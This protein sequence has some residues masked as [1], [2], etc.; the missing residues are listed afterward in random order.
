MVR[1]RGCGRMKAA[2]S[3]LCVMGGEAGTDGEGAC[4]SGAGCMGRWMRYCVDG[5]RD[6]MAAAAAAA[7]CCTAVCHLL[8]GW[9]RYLPG[10]GTASVPD[11]AWCHSREDVTWCADKLLSALAWVGMV[12]A[13]LMMLMAGA[14]CW[15]N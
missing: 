9:L 10:W 5:A 7:A 2:S 1:G 4:T 14:G 12:V 15:C 6:V 13:W 3:V 8:A 11:A